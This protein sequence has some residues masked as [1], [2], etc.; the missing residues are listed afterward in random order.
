M[1]QYADGGLMAS[2]PYIASGKYID[3]MSPHCAQC[4]HDPAQRVGDK[5]CPFTT[6]YWDFL[7]RHEALLAKNPRML[8]QVR[9]AQRLSADDRLAIQEQAQRHRIAMTPSTS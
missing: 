2:K 9:N 5:A 6:L 4:P 1:S 8:P 7:I 3:R